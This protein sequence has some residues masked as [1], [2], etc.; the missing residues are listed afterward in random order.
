MSSETII[1]WGYRLKSTNVAFD[2]ISYTQTELTLTE[3]SCFGIIESKVTD[4]SKLNGAVMAYI[5]CECGCHPVPFHLLLQTVEL[6]RNP[7]LE[8]NYQPRLAVTEQLYV[9]G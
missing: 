6:I 2:S 7:H 5:I 3:T 8:S 1:P 9:T 4:S